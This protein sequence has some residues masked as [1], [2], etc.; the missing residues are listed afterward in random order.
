M[1]CNK[2]PIYLDL[3]ADFFAFFLTQVKKGGEREHFLSF[4]LSTVC[5]DCNL[6]LVVSHF[7]EMYHDFNLSW[8][9]YVCAVWDSVNKNAE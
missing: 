9:W 6:A 8:S 2:I 5:C 1:K 7:M 3:N 4:S